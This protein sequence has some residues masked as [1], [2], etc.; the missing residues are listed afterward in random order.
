M[1]P[2][3]RGA[4]TEARLGQP[5]SCR[6]RSGRRRPRDARTVG[7]R[8]AEPGRPGGGQRRRCGRWPEDGPGLYPHA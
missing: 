8:R 5:N 6:C 4:A 3:P 1:D 2:G 7:A